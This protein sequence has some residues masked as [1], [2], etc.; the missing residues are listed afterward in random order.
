MV[1]GCWL[2]LLLRA[3]RGALVFYG[4]GE[5]KRETFERGGSCEGAGGQV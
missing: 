5:G 3:G 4:G 1:V 2:L